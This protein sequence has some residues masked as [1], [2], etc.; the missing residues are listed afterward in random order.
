MSQPELMDEIDIFFETTI[1]VHLCVTDYQKRKNV[2]RG[3]S[4][5]VE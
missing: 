3:F 1:D 5:E 4:E 2:G